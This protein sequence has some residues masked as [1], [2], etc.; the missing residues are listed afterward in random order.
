MPYPNSD[1]LTILVNHYK[2]T[3]KPQWNSIR[4]YFADTYNYYLRDASQTGAAKE[5]MCTEILEQIA[6]ASAAAT[7]AKME[8]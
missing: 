3:R 5:K 1:H 8:K 6:L 4:G 7:G 2:D